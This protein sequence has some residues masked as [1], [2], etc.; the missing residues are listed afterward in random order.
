MN[1]FLNNLATATHYNSGKGYVKALTWHSERS[2][3]DLLSYDKVPMLDWDWPNEGHKSEESITITNVNQVIKILTDYLKHH[4]YQ[5]IKLY[6]TP[7]GVRAF[8]LGKLQTPEEFFTTGGGETLGADPLYINL[9]K[10]IKAFS[11]RVSAKP[12]RKGDFVASHY[13]TLGSSNAT[14]VKKLSLMLIKSHDTYI[15]ER[16]VKT[17]C[18][19][20]NW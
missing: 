5:V 7:G 8:F 16:R 19:N 10:N 9:A 18:V 3:I 2:Q 6:V 20:Y 13:V 15:K 1:K 11:V 17:C 4:P 14:L 12:N